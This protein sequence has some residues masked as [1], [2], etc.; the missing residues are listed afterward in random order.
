MNYWDK[1][2]RSEGKIW[3]E[4]P[5][6]TLELAIDY[7]SKNN[8]CKV[9]VPG[10]GYGRNA[11][12]LAKAGFDVF[13][14]ESSEVAHKMAVSSN[15]KRGLEIDYELGNV[16]EMPYGDESFEG[17]YCFNTLHFFK[18]DERIRFIEETYRIL[19]RCGLAVF[20]VFSEKEHSFGKGRE[21][22]SNTFESKKG[23]PAHYFSE[24]DLNEHFKNYEILVNTI[25][26]EPE[27]HGS[28]PHIHILR[29]IVARKNDPLN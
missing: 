4:K 29:L 14:V 2:F 5:S 7:F 15:E 25:I 22:E 23:R 17:V 3:G 19:K 10:S 13:G 21:I 28:G 20:T 6:I 1:R 24:K 27:N 8:V 26:E 9:L 11:E 12:A 18:R 16:L